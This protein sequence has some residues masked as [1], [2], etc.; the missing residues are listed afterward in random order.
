MLKIISDYPDNLDDDIF[1]LLQFALISNTDSNKNNPIFEMHDVISAKIRE[2]NNTEDNIKY[3]EDIL[4]KVT[5]AIPE[6]VVQ[7]RVFIA[8]MEK[9]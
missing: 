2:I 1:Q 6:G 5:K 7:G 4:D 9:F 8:N 3:L